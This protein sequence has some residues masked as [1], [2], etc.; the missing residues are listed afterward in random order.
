MSIIQEH[1]G[2]LDYVNAK[3][4]PEAIERGSFL[5][6]FLTACLLADSENFELLKP[7]LEKL[8]VKYPADPDRLEA[9][10]R[11]RGLI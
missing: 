7:V 5:G 3:L 9:Q 8:A 6:C 1:P 4:Y 11:D 2:L 10:R